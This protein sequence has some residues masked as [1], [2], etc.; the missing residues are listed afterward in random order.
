ML[1]EAEAAGQ[2]HVLRNSHVAAIRDTKVLLEVAGKPQEVQ[3]DY[4]FILIGGNSPE[5]FLKRTGVEIV[6]KSL[7]VNLEKSFA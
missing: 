1:A 3:N 6:E 2:L 7:S 5:E 4:V